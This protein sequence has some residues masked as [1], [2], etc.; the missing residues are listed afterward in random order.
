MTNS[1]IAWERGINLSEAVEEFCSELL[2]D[3]SAALLTEFPITVDIR[4]RKI[5]YEP[6]LPSAEYLAVKFSRQ[7][8]I[9]TEMR[10]DVL[11]RLRTGGLLAVGF[12]MPRRRS[13]QPVAISKELWSAFYPDWEACSL[14]AANDVFQE[15]RVVEVDPESE[16]AK[17]IKLASKPRALP[18]R[19]SHIDLIVRIYERLLSENRIAWKYLTDNVELIQKE[20]AEEFRATGCTSDVPEIQTI[21][22]A[23]G[24]RFKADRTTHQKAQELTQ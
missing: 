8:S 20:I 5:N 3:E 4:P 11:A 15:I 7:Q 9:I 23:I 24:A 19:P 6:V 17:T 21:R 10:A 1:R 14:A 12:K 22:N 18:G 13:D 2:W 16:V